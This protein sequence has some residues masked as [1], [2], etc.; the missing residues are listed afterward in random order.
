VVDSLLARS[1]REPVH[2]SDLG[3]ADALRALCNDAFAH[4][5]AGRFVEA[6]RLYELVLSL[7]PELTDLHNNLGHALLAQ[8]RPEAA[9]AAFAR[10]IDLKPNNPEALC[11]W[12]LALA[13]LQRFDAA[14]AK[15]LQAIAVNPRFA[16]AYNNLGLLLKERGRL[17]EARAAFEKAIDLEPKTFA[18]YDNLTKVRRFAI[19][20]GYLAALETAA[21][22]AT[23]LSAT[24]QMHLHFA[25][26]KTCDDLDRPEDAFRHWLDANRLKR[27]QIDYDEAGTL[28]AMARLRGGIDRD[29]IQ[30][31]RGCGE[32]SAVPVFIVGM[33]RSGTTLI[34]QILASHPDVFGGGELPLLDQVAGSIRHLLPG[35]PAFPE[36]MLKMSPAHYRALGALYLDRIARRAPTAKR[37]T[38]KMTVNFL[39]I[40]LIHLVLPNATIIHA[41]RDP[42]DTCVSCFAT[43]FANGNEHTYDLAE[44]G[45]YWRQYREL[46]A[47]WHDMLPPGRILD[48]PYEELVSDPEAASR[49]IVA[50]CG[51][52][53]DPRCLDFH[54]TQRPVRTASAAQVR[55]PIYQNSVGRWRKYEAFLAPLFEALGPFADSSESARELET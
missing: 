43:H 31:H 32:P 34:E 55:K 51:L 4:H 14:E 16:G 18:Y 50:H 41:V 24:D 30:A 46:M 44:L 26:G 36:M 13:E 49:R 45:R 12:G 33:T 42:A 52:P 29:F 54:R 6:I 37:I 15:Y 53:W 21:T 22:G 23:E 10:A 20:D 5:R 48:V 8:G 7:R 3:L 2:G 17:T 35:A 27:Q 1:D 39:F 9:V 19:G 40:G 28:G 11:N 47:H 38:D 25:L